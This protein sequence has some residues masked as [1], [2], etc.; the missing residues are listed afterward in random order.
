MRRR[1]ELVDGLAGLR[2][3]RKS[4]EWPLQCDH[5]RPEFARDTRRTAH[6]GDLI[7]D[8]Q[9]LARHARSAE[10]SCAAPLDGPALRFAVLVRRFNLHECMRIAKD[11]LHQ[12]ALQL[13]F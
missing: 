6:N 1:I 8:S 9:R 11:E 5:Q 4:I 3:P 2:P 13:D 12:L 7:A 10:L